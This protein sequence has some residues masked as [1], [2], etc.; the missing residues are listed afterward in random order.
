MLERYHR[1]IKKDAIRP[2]AASSIDQAKAVVAKFVKHCNC[3]R[4]HSAISYITPNDFLAG[5]QNAIWA[6]RVTRTLKPPAKLG[7]LVEPSAMRISANPCFVL[8]MCTGF[9]F[10]S[11]INLSSRS[12]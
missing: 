2:S 1:A 6:R 4:L 10:R 9:I 11:K 3:V 7:A 8:Q 12:R 5:R